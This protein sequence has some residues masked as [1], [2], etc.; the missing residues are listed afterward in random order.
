MFRV[1]SETVCA[2]LAGPYHLMDAKYIQ[3]TRVCLLLE[4]CHHY[5]NFPSVCWFLCFSDT[6]IS[7][8]FCPVLAWTAD[9]QTPIDKI[10]MAID[11][12]EVLGNMGSP[13]WCIV[14]IFLWVILTKL[15]T[16]ICFIW[17]FILGTGNVWTSSR[18]HN[19]GHQC[20]NTCTQ[21]KSWPYVPKSSR[22]LFVQWDIPLTHQPALPDLCCSPAVRQVTS[23]CPFLCPPWLLWGCGAL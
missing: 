17:P 4:K 2:L 6:G 13:K 23:W 19:W 18:A 1:P 15:N 20:F 22:T 10:F 8:R 12:G 5:K 11:F 16:V 14:M 3:V 7:C 21:L 9:L